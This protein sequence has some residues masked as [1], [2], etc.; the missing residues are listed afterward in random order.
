MRRTGENR[1]SHDMAP[2]RFRLAQNYPNP[3][4]DMTTIKYCVPRRTRIALTIYGA[5][6]EVVHLLMDEIKEPGTYEVVWDAKNVAHGIYKYE[7]RAAD[8]QAVKK[9]EVL[10]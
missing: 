5:D 2:S 6:G 10:K 9:M 3:F 1:I 8:Y 7:L 4:S